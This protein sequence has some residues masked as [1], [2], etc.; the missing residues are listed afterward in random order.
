MVPLSRIILYVEDVERLSVFHRQAFALPLASE[1]VGNKRK[2]G[3]T[4]RRK[5]VEPSFSSRK[6]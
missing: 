2:H 3:L 5:S 4:R 1:T 6:A